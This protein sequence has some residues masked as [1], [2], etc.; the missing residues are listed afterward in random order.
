MEKES[1]KNKNHRNGSNYI[2]YTGGVTAAGIYWQTTNASSMLYSAIADENMGSRDGYTINPVGQPGYDLQD[3]AYKAQQQAFYDLNIAPYL[4]PHTNG[5]IVYN[6]QYWP[7]GGA[8]AGPSTNSNNVG[9]G[10]AP[11][12]GLITAAPP[13]KPKPPKHFHFYKKYN[14][15]GIFGTGFFRQKQVIK[16]NIKGK[17]TSGGC[18]R[19]NSKSYSDKIKVIIDGKVTKQ[20]LVWEPHSKDPISPYTDGLI[21]IDI[22]EG[23]QDIKIIL[24]PNRGHLF[25]LIRNPT[26]TNDYF[27]IDIDFDYIEDEIR[28][29]CPS[30]L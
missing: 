5:T 12:R 24:K 23:S 30:N 16:P 21:D 8:P 10:P 22:P 4:V 25:S 17:T 14:E 11:T 7:T 9:G 27:D 20:K 3:A 13:I 6:S 19:F 26:Y 18:I 2:M 29:P 15:K 28:T 1:A